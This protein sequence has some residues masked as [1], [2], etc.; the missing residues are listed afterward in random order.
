MMDLQTGDQTFP[1]TGTQLITDHTGILL[2]S[3]TFDNVYVKN[4]DHWVRV[5]F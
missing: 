2:V 1:G 4:W 3:F 5:S